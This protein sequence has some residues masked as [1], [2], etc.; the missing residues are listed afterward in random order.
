MI[1]IFENIDNYVMLHY[2]LL[3]VTESS[4]IEFFSKTIFDRT[5]LSIHFEPILMVQK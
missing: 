1:F 3:K 2:Y 5:G 4:A